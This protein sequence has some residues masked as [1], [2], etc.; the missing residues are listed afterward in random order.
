M[1]KVQKATIT[2]CSKCKYRCRVGNFGHN[3]WV[4]CNYLDIAGKSRIFVNGEQAIPT[5]YCDKYEYGE[6]S[7]TSAKRWCDQSFVNEVKI[8]LEGIRKWET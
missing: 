4:S 6:Q 2:L 8:K 3:G 5:G 1:G 7:L